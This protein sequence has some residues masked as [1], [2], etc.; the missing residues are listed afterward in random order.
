[1]TTTSFVRCFIELHSCRAPLVQGLRQVGQERPGSSYVFI[2]LV[3]GP[4]ISLGTQ[5]VVV[6]FCVPNTQ[7]CAWGEEDSG[8][9]VL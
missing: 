3:L 7:L 5:W 9:H 4:L 2:Q 8:G 1:M 6:Y